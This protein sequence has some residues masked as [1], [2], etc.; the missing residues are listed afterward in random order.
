[1]KMLYLCTKSFN[2]LGGLTVKL[3]GEGFEVVV[4]ERFMRCGNF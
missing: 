3:F 1:M 4:L 2:I